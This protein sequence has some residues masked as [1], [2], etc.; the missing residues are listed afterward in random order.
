MRTPEITFLNLNRKCTAIQGKET[1]CLN[2]FCGY[3][4]WSNWSPFTQCLI[5]LCPEWN[6]RA[7]VFLTS[8]WYILAWW[9]KPWCHP[10]V[11]SVA[12]VS[13]SV[14]GTTSYCVHPPLLFQRRVLPRQ[15]AW[16]GAPALQL[17]FMLAVKIDLDWFHSNRTFSFIAL[18]KHA[19]LCFEDGPESLFRGPK[20]SSSS[21]KLEEIWKH[22]CRNRTF[23]EMWKHLCRNRSPA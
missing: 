19:T 11:F 21:L 16:E 22:L 14:V 12:F 15:A 1:C 4:C 23:G 8:W 17:A 9:E 13:R 10:K 6:G 20:P 5:S 3:L 7:K 18:V 2:H